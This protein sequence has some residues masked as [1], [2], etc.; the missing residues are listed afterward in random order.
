MTCWGTGSARHRAHAAGALRTDCHGS[1]D[2][3]RARV[4]THSSQFRRRT[5]MPPMPRFPAPFSM[6]PPPNQHSPQRVR[7]GRCGRH[8]GSQVYKL[9][10]ELYDQSGVSYTNIR[11]LSSASTHPRA[12]R[13]GRQTRARGASSPSTRRE[14]PRTSSAPACYSARGLHADRRDKLLKWRDTRGSQLHAEQHRHRVLGAALRRPAAHEDA[15]WAL[16]PG[17]APR[18]AP[19][20]PKSLQYFMEFRCDFPTLI[21]RGLSPPNGFHPNAYTLSVSPP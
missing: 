7:A 5:A 1:L 13:A 17:P 8:F 12:T 10:C 2:V 14:R 11:K 15:P 20:F 3:P 9:L 19:A 21:R 16:Q 6:Y 18:S 4:S